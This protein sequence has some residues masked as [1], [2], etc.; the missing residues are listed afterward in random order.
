MFTW[1]LLAS[2]TKLSVDAQKETGTRRLG[3]ALLGTPAPLARRSP[4]LAAPL[5][6]SPAASF[7]IGAFVRAKLHLD[8]DPEVLCTTSRRE[9]QALLS[10]VLQADLE[11]GDEEQRGKCVRELAYVARSCGARL[12]IEGQVGA[13]LG[14][15]RCG[16]SQ[17]VAPRACDAAVNVLALIGSTDAQGQLADAFVNGHVP[18]EWC[19]ENTLAVGSIVE[20][21]HNLLDAMTTHLDATADSHSDASLLLA[22]SALAS[23][24]RKRSKR[25]ALGRVVERVDA[26]IHKR[27]ADAKREEEHVWA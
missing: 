14:S 10:C 3:T 9:V 16:G 19:H 6:A 24:S 27:L 21:H 8:D 20:P 23:R 22:T 7:E 12:G 15:A 5:T 26:I 13:I 4:S 11:G 2:T 1:T 17:S 18:S 25:D